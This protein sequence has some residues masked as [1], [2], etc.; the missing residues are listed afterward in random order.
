VHDWTTVQ[1]NAGAIF[2]HKETPFH[3]L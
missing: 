1:K 3:R 2:D